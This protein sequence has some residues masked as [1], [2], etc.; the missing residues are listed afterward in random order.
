M[1]QLE[2]MTFK[3]LN[4]MVLAIAEKFFMAKK[5]HNCRLADRVAE[6][7][8]DEQCPFD[9]YLLKVE[10]AYETLSESEKNLINNEFF[11]QNYHQWWKPIYSKATF[12]RYKKEAMQ[13]FLGAFFNA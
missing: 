6:N 3:D 12:Y 2:N 4:D 8:F 7:D 5:I 10:S 11:F 9:H 13:K 1:S